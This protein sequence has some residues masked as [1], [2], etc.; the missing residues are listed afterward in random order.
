MKMDDPDGCVS[1]NEFAKRCLR[2]ED[3]YP[4][5]SL[6]HYENLFFYIFLNKSS[7]SLDYSVNPL[8]TVA[9]CVYMR[10]GD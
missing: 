10:I 9:L 2:L 1:S 3:T 5:G 8:Y 7:F 6:F 4:S